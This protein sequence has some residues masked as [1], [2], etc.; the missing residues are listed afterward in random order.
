M[1]SKKSGTLVLRFNGCGMQSAVGFWSNYG[2]SSQIFS[3]AWS[4][5]ILWY[6]SIQ[7]MLIQVLDTFLDFCWPFFEG[8]GIFFG[9]LFV[10]FWCFFCFSGLGL[11]VF[12]LLAF[13]LL[14][15]WFFGF[16][17]LSA[18][19]FWPLLAFGFWLLLA[20][21]LWPLLAF[22]FW[23]L[24]AFVGFWLFASVGFWLWAFVGFWLLAFCFCWLPFWPLLAYGWLWLW[25]LLLL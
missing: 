16:W 13:W 17:L 25:L 21:G 14:A 18:F 3:N 11:L 10:F 2:F 20:F 9:I 4:Q 5:L 12:W 15:F 8:G 7:L 23:L 6:N 1:F 22:G 24:L 19:G